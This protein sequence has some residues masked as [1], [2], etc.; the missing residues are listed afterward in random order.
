[1]ARQGSQTQF[2]TITGLIVPRLSDSKSN[3]EHDT[4]GEDEEEEGQP[5]FLDM[6]EMD[7][8]SSGGNMIRSFTLELKEVSILVG[9]KTYQVW[10][11]FP[12]CDP[13]WEV[14]CTIKKSHGKNFII[15]HPFYRLRTYLGSETRSLVSLFLKECQ[16]KPEFVA[17]FMEWLP[18]ERHMELVSLLDILKEYEDSS[19]ERKPVAK[20]LIS[21]VN[22][23]AAWEHVKVGS[24]YPYIMQYLPTLLPQKFLEIIK[25]TELKEPSEPSQSDHTPPEEQSASLLD[26]LEELIKTDVWK[27]GFNYIM[28]KELHLIRCEAKLEAFKLCGLFFDLSTLHQNALILYADL[29]KYCKQTGSTYYMRKNL[30][31][32][33]MS[34]TGVDGA[35]EALR[36]LVKEGVLVQETDKLALRNLHSYEKGIAKCLKSLVE[37]VPWKIQL[38]V[39][40]ILQRESKTCKVEAHVEISGPISVNPGATSMDHNGGA[41]TQYE[42]SKLSIEEEADSD[43]SNDSPY[44]NIDPDSIELDPD[45]V[46]AAEMICAHPVTVIS[47]K[48]G[49]GKTTVVSL[50]FKAA[51]L[52]QKSDHEEVQKACE[53]FK[54]D[55]LGSDPTL[56]PV[57]EHE[58]KEGPEKSYDEGMKILLTA[59]TGR[60]ASLLTKR[61]GFT[62]YTMHQILCSFMKF[63]EQQRSN[64]SPIP[65]KWRFSKV[66]VLVVDEGSL[67]CV[68]ILHSVLSILC[69][70]A[71]LQKFI[72]LGD[73]RQLPSIDPGNTLY[74]LFKVLR[75]EHWAIEMQTNHRAESELIVRNAGLIS[76]MGKKGHY[77]PL[78]FDAV[79]DVEAPSTEAI[80]FLLHNAPGLK[81]DK[82]SQFVAFRRNDCDLIN[83]LCCKYYSGHVTKTS[84]NK[85]NFQIKDKVCCTKNGRVAYES[86]QK[87]ASS[88]TA[89]PSDDMTPCDDTGRQGEEETRERLCNGEIFFIVD[90]V[91]KPDG[92][93]QKMV[94]FL[95]LD[96]E[97]DLK[98]TCKY[99]ELQRECKLRHAWARTIHTFQGSEAETIVY[100]LGNCRAQNWQHVYTAV[101]RGRKRVYVVGTERDLEES[102]TKRITPRNT[103]L[104]NF[105][106]KEIRQHR[107]QD[108]LTQTACTQ[109]QT[110]TPVKPLQSTTLVKYV[111]TQSS[112]HPSFKCRLNGQEP[113]SSNISLQDDLAFS[114]AYSWSP[115]NICDEPETEN[116]ENAS[117]IS[118]S[119]EQS[120]GSKRLIPDDICTTPVKLPKQTSPV[121]SP[122]CS[123][124][125][126]LLSIASP[127]SKST[128]SLRDSL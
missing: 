104:C 14:R 41:L 118:N 97:N 95:T 126:K 83:E 88:E 102:I 49:S 60:A 81:E 33:L 17:M 38:D 26:R 48:G 37:G 27:L 28:F 94:R 122:L 52:Q 43:S 119:T 25:K 22:I 79:L 6:N 90:D 92:I 62:A 59:P 12:L 93:R 117:C 112:T 121:E 8:V 77:G 15:G 108:S 3:Q 1:M 58:D 116:N 85:Q 125:L 24:T 55:S 74:D 68:Q 34:E 29:K 106:T 72:I 44:L 82:Q 10:G 89:K 69:K 64:D 61:T 66:R 50:V 47:G 4:E 2:Q 39:K 101:T 86:E 107:P 120:G 5:E 123:S 127:D 70:N 16:T 111:S 113:P 18:N 124:K 11:R 19:P 54:I 13:W 100:V 56:R 99:K 115:M 84:K 109:T 51:M 71:E 45:Q 103:R 7:S 73:V 36:F 128:C 35:W 96:D 98:I 42:S 21:R 30:E 46:R 23:S 80:S 65:K 78:E 91:T 57:E 105:I 75:K 114:Q 20:E 9:T 31:H 87:S 32:R 76:Q 110:Q 40:D 67:V 63:K 53:D